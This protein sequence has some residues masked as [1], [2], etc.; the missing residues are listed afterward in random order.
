[1]I[2]LY[3]V[4]WCAYAHRVRQLLT[5]LGLTYTIVNVPCAHG[6]RA[7]L[8]AISGQRETPVLIDNE[9]IY[10]SSD[11]I[12]AY[13]RAT[14]PAAADAKNHAQRGAWRSKTAVS[15]TPQATLARLE[16]LLKSEGFNIVC[17]TQGREIH[18]DLPENY[19]LLQVM[20]P[21]AAAKALTADPLAAVAAMLPLAV[22]PAEDGTSVVAAAD[23]IGQVWL[24]G[25]PTLYVIQG[26]VKKRLL[27][28]LKEL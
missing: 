10:R 5:E 26:T 6:D 14:Y 7:E 18:P 19:V 11:E 9:Q 27:T 16:Q 23:P 3:Q 25:D 17:Q 15:L 20:L 1:M 13:L 28:L 2:T 21:S 8:V 22:V 12:I 4:E 24:Y